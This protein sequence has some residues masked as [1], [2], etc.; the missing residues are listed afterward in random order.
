MNHPRPSFIS[1]TTAF[2]EHRKPRLGTARRKLALGPRTHVRVPSEPWSYA[3]SPLDFDATKAAARP[4]QLRAHAGVGTPEHAIDEMERP[5][6]ARG[7][8][9]VVRDDDQARSDVTIQL[10]HQ[11]E[12][13]AL[14]C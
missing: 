5:V 2:I 6:G 3:R 9:G 13:L 11:I 12:D 10:E 4:L 14:S 8:L 7:E 1:Y